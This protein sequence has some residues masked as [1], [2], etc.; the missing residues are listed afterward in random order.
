M[1]SSRWTITEDVPVHGLVALLLAEVQVGIQDLVDGTLVL[2][3]L[4]EE[5]QLLAVLGLEAVGS[6]TGSSSFLF[7]YEERINYGTKRSV[8]CAS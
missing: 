4:V 5:L 8:R 6:N 7:I 2:R 1:V 3:Y